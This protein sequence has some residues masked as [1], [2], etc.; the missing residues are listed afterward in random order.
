MS[1]SILSAFG[2]ALRGFWRVLDASRRALL[3]LLLLVLLIAG[4]WAAIQAL[5]PAIEPKTALVLDLAGPV[6]E[7]RD[8]RLRNSLFKELGELPDRATR[9]RDVIAVL[10][11]AAKDERVP[12]ALLLLDDF[13]GAGLPTLREIAAAVERFK[14][15]GKPVYA[16]GSSFDQ[17]QYYLAAHATEVW[18]HPMGM[19][20]VEGYGRW[21][22]YYKDL[23]DRVGVTAHVLRVGQFK[24]FAEPFSANAPSQEALEAE[25]ALYAS[26]W[27]SWTTGVE[28]ARQLPA[29][30]VAQAI[31][32]LPGS[33]QAAGGNPARW[34]LER[35][36]VDALKTRDEVRALLTERGV[37]DDDNKSFRQVAMRRYLG[38]VKPPRSGDTVGVIVAQGE[39]SDGRQPP[40][41]L[42]GLSTA[43]LVRQAR[44][45]EDI[46][47]VVLRVNS[48]GGSAFG[49]ELVR[50]ELELTRAAGKPVVV[51]MGDVAASGGYWISMAAD[52]V[53]ADEATIT[54]SI[55]VVALLPTAEGAMDKLGVRTGGVATTW[56]AG[57]YDPRRAFD[58]PFGQLVQSII[59]RAY[60]DFTTLAAKA[61]QTTPERIDEV[62]QGRVWS[63]RQALELGLVDR[64]GGLGD[65]LAAAARRAG[66]SEGHRVQYLE[67]QSGRL[68]RL[69][70]DFGAVV[71]AAVGAAIGEP[72][73]LPA[74]WLALGGV[75]PMA[76]DMVHDL[77]WLA[78]VSERRQPLSAVVHCLCSAP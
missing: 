47:A 46:K 67:V 44:E 18:L 52:E 45:D 27:Q 5:R 69:L 55:G 19:V 15:A 9:L 71:G 40:G 59:D 1:I 25:G 13:A 75:V 16:W 63:G 2:R 11:A 42:G 61:R 64:N 70:Q 73:H 62:G 41:R 65:A 53:I 76:N 57:A 35:K 20:Y 29:G 7:Q 77:D 54:G 51:S 66:L 50:R 33:L 10:D 23:L 24:S 26:L 17:R 39:I 74:A 49:S 4:L 34:A 56:L 78:E 48:P 32:S 3:N 14:A 43:E 37:R 30:S 28:K 6:V 12:H 36:W 22:N 21:R 60:L 8:V 72:L 68:Q 31:D 38:S 58:P